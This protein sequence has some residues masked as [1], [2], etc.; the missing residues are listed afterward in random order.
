[1]RRLPESQGQGEVQASPRGQGQEGPPKTSASKSLKV[2]SHTLRK[3]LARADARN[4]SRP[5]HPVYVHAREDRVTEAKPPE[6]Q[7]ADPLL[8]SRGR[9]TQARA[10]SEAVASADAGITDAPDRARRLTRRRV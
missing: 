8:E 4:G 7:E 10:L 5:V 9:F 3:A 1:V 6:D 2:F